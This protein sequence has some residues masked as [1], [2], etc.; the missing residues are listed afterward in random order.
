MN[1][2]DC[3][4]LF[5][6]SRRKEFFHLTRLKSEKQASK[7]DKPSPKAVFN[8]EQQGERAHQRGS[9]HPTGRLLGFRPSASLP[10]HHSASPALASLS[11]GSRGGHGG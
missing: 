1:T 5:F 7:E 2:R 11:P 9:E 4:R 10:Q 6:A 8:R 3:K